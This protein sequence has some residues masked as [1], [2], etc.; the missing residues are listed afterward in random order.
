MGVT[1]FVVHLGGWDSNPASVSKLSRLDRSFLAPH[2]RVPRASFRGNESHHISAVSVA[3]P[4][5]DRERR[6][7]LGAVRLQGT[8]PLTAPIAVPAIDIAQL[9]AE[10]SRIYKIYVVWRTTVERGRAWA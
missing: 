4:H 8:S 10:R 3:G 7:P 6:T 9:E 5:V 1:L 2:P